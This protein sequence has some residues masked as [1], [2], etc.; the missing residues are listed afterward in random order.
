MRDVRS[1][2][3]VPATDE[4]RL[5]KAH[6]RG[7][8]CLILD[9]E[10][11]ASAVAKRAARAALPRLIGDLAARAQNVAVRV[12]GSPSQLWDD[13]TAAVHP[14]LRTLVA[15]KIDHPDSLAEVVSALRTA[16]TRRGLTQG[17]IGVI[18]LIESPRGLEQVSRIADVPG[19]VGLAL[20]VEDFSLALGVE[21]GPESLDLPCRQLALTAASRGL[22]A[23][24]APVSISTF[25][26]PSF[27]GAAALRAKAM[28]MTG[29]LCIHPSQVVQVKL[30]FA[31]S[32]AQIA[33]ARLIQAAWAA[34]PDAAAVIRIGDRMIDAPLVERAERLLERLVSQAQ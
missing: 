30:A 26:P 1:Y 14:G 12:D 23:I 8:D 5:R 15:P 17:A 22:A 13:V 16:E 2:L 7:A 18:A 31:P 34:R 24:G 28:G 10:D 3:F 27:Y 21:P 19:L 6:T 25:D 33:E 32:D 9:L 20:G 29:V 11:G 4:V